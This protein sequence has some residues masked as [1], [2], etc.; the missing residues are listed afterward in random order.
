MAIASNVPF[1]QSVNLRVGIGTSNVS[2][3]GL[4]VMSG[5][6]GI[7]TSSTANAVLTVINGNVGFGVT[8]P[9]RAL[10]IKNYAG[11][12]NDT[13]RLGRY[14]SSAYSSIDYFPTYNT[15]ASSSAPS[16]GS[17]YYGTSGNNGFNIWSYN[18]V[19]NT[20]D[21]YI[22][23]GSNI[24]IGSTVPGQKLDV[25]GT[26][27]AMYFIGN[28]ASLTGVPGT[29]LWTTSNTNDVYLPNS[30]NV[31]IG[32]TITNAGAALSVMNGNVGIGTWVPSAPLQVNGQINSF[33]LGNSTSIIE[34]TNGTSV[35]TN[36][37]SA[38]GITFSSTYIGPSSDYSS[39]LGSS[40]AIGQV[41][42]R[43]WNNAYIKRG[44]FF[45]NVV[46]G[47]YANI[48]NQFV[49]N[50]AVGIGTANSSYV[51]TTAPSGGLIVQGNVGIG[52]LSPGTALGVNG[53]VRAT[54]FI[55]NGAQLTGVPSSNL[56][57]V[58]NTNDVYLPSPGNVGI[59]TTFT[60][61]GAALSV[62][63]GN[64]GIGTWVPSAALQVTGQYYST[65]FT[66]TTTLDWNKSNVQY[67]QLAS[68]GQTFTFAHPNGGG[69]YLLILKQPS[70]GAAGT[71][72]WPSTVSWQN[73]VTPT[74]T[75][76]NSQ[77]DVIT[78]IYDSANEQY[79][80]S[81]SLNYAP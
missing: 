60:S 62:M 46:I 61:S 41:I 36:T 3:A 15:S 2:K 75:T 10:D 74:L 5:N 14:S 6:V 29:T 72:T 37:N 50:G 40:F 48:N 42:D 53:T 13:I 67:I 9:Q 69:R 78:F 56:W 68:G 66:T 23:P 21:F 19:S 79:Y 59:G 81:A 11:S 52:S 76:T 34:N 17:G 63:K 16:W 1:N 35:I 45:N 24:G 32:T 22:D 7:G 26:V 57:T 4:T 43:R 70:S 47:T 49:V 65:Q 25:Q 73:G 51:T 39:D 12:G 27:R 30:G 18:N 38:G 44:I 80:G 20:I 28:G 33:S 8:N 77:V 71:V 54:A 55:G 58:T 64:V 31:G